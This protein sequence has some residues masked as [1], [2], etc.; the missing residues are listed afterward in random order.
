M[1]RRFHAV[2]ETTKACETFHNKIVL[3]SLSCLQRPLLP[4]GFQAADVINKYLVAGMAG[5]AGVFKYEP[6][7]LHLLGMIVFQLDTIRKCIWHRYLQL[8]LHILAT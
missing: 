5:V 4:A 3:I 1:S 7:M 6:R 2:A 8:Y